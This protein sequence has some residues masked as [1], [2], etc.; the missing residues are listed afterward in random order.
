MQVTHEEKLEANEC[1]GI[2]TITRS[3]GENLAVDFYSEYRIG[4]V[5]SKNFIPVMGIFPGFTETQIKKLWGE[6][7]KDGQN[8]LYYSEKS[9]DHDRD[10][11]PAK[12]IININLEKDKVKSISVS[13]MFDDC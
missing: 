10:Y 11:F 13:K 1:S 7:A 3:Y 4:Y 8:L 5:F 6:P 2:S 9:S 12:W